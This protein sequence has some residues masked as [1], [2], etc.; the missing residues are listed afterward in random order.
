MLDNRWRK[1]NK[2]RCYKIYLDKLN[3]IKVKI[4][5]HHN[6]NNNNN[7]LNQINK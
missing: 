3:K 7:K 5:K 4:N 1:N 2:K 6:N